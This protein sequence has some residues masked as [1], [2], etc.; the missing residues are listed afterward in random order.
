MEKARLVQERKTLTWPQPSPPQIPNAK[1][2]G[3]VMCAIPR[4]KRVTSELNTQTVFHILREEPAIL[5][6]FR[7]Q[8]P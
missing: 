4:S 6:Q 1:K 5:K 7:T 8:Y 2:K 3:R